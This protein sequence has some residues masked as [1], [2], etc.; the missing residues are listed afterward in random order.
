MSAFSRGI[1][2][3]VLLAAFETSAKQASGAARCGQSWRPAAAAPCAPMRRWRTGET[4]H[5]CNVTTKLI[6]SRRWIVLSSD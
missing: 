1:S 2:I 4:V 6:D 3:V 5:G